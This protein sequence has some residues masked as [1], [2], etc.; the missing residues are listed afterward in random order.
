MICANNR[1]RKKYLCLQNPLTG[2]VLC[3]T[4]LLTVVG[5]AQDAAVMLTLDR[6]IER[7][8]AV[9]QEHNYQIKLQAGQCAWIEVE[10]RGINVLLNVFAPD[11]KYVFWHDHNILSETTGTERAIIIADAPGDY[12]LWIAPQVPPNAKNITPGKYSVKIASLHSAT[13]AEQR[14]FQAQIL[15]AWAIQRGYSNDE[16][17]KSE[18]IKQAQEWHRLYRNEGDTGAL[19]KILQLLG[20]HAILQRNFT[21]SADYHQ[22]LIALVQATGDQRRRGF[23]LRDISMQYF[24]M[25]EYQ[26]ALNYNIQELTIWQRLGDRSLQASAWNRRAYQYLRLRQIEKSLDAHAQRLAIVRELKDAALEA[27]TLQNI[28]NV[29]G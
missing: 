26:T 7:D 29:Y 20:W 18:G 28:A 15:F 5:K 13:E 12:R 9:G 8:L 27:D 4:L 14:I 22:Q 17:E 10:Q 3:L 2:V 6:P 11:G 21:Q 23:M 24:T 19:Q 1:L 16:K 25:R